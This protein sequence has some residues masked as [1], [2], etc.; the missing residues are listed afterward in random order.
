M[1]DPTL[2]SDL[3]AAAV[4]AALAAGSEIATA[5]ADPDAAL[6]VRTTGG[7]VDFVTRVD[8][9]AEAAAL[10]V[11]R[12]RYPDHEVLAEESGH[13]AGDAAF[14]WLI[15][16]LDGTTN[17]SHGHPHCAVSIACLDADG[18]LVGVIYDPARGERFEAVRG[19]GAWLNGRPMRVS[20]R[21][22][23]ADCLFA[24]GFAY[25]RRERAHHYVPI[26]EA[27]MRLGHGVRRMGAAALDLA[28]VA[29]GRL[30]GFW[31]Y[32]LAPWDVA[33]GVLLVGE[34]G[35]AVSDYRGGALRVDEPRRIVA[36]NGLIHAQ[37]LEVLATHEALWA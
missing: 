13:T 6:E 27:F 10:A 28:W 26:F 2:S 14:R 24:T 34:A 9:A 18:P 25:D 3:R 20:G 21:E 29:A 16:P 22:Q 1:A 23:A 33:A 36:S 19:E 7:A 15:D 12:A 31:E 35:G 17:F 5:L 8:L 11:L 32:G 37:M 4:T 30:D